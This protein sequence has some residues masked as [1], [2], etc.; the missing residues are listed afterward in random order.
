MLKFARFAGAQSLI[1]EDEQFQH[2]L[3]ILNTNVDGRHKVMYAMTKIRGVGR[4]F[5]NMIVKKSQIDLAKR[6]ALCLRVAL[7]VLSLVVALNS[8]GELTEDEIE[9]LKNVIADP[10]QFNIPEWCGHGGTRWLHADALGMQVPQ[11]SARPQG[12]QDLA[13]HS[14][15]LGYQAA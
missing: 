12:Q 3:R 2:I 4:R 7:R 13:D 15:E 14:P 9:T 8:A 10:Q 11:P 1:V 6:C 5:S